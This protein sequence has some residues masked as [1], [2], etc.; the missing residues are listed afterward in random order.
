MNG[1]KSQ[2]F[3][4]IIF[5]AKFCEERVWLVKGYNKRENNENVKN[6]SR[7]IKSFKSHFYSCQLKTLQF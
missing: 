2:V 1:M 4:F 6:Y 3:S 7:E 5:N